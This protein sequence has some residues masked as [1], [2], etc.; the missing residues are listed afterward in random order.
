MFCDTLQTEFITSGVPELFHLLLFPCVIK[1]L[2]GS[3]LEQGVKLKKSSENQ[4]CDW[5]TSQAV[6]F[7]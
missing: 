2:Y 3:K 4:Q 1:C 7:K 6:V 5:D